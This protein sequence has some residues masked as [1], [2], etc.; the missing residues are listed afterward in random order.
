MESKSHVAHDILAYIKK[1]KEVLYLE[2]YIHI[3]EDLNSRFMIILECKRVS[4]RDDS[5][6]F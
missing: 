1:A 5:F 6:F 2:K 3:V 4:A